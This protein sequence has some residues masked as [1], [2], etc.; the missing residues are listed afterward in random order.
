MRKKS[1]GFTLIELITVIVIL[2]VLATAIST[3]IKF[4]TQVYSE[5]TARDQLV[6]SARFAVERINREI[7]N[8]LPNSLQLTNSNQCIEFTPII[9]NTIYTDI[10]V[11][12]EIASDKISVILF[13]EAFD[14]NWNVI[15][16][17]LIPD[18]VYGN[19]GKIYS[20]DSI[21]TVGDEWVITL[22]NNVLFA[23]DSPTQRVYFINESVEY[24]LSGETLTRNGILMAQDIHN[25]NAN[26][27]FEVLSSTLQRNAMVQIH[28]EFEKNNEQI[29]FNNEV[30]VLNVP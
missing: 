2:G 8:S 10:P 7:R 20:V 27:P 9:E 24:C 18:D 11:L 6:S 1:S 29:T 19:T 21:I 4:G 22:D 23:E 14:S 13:D 3:F 30:Q 26:P 15:V 16:Y 5:T 25:T 12:P 17:P 28:L